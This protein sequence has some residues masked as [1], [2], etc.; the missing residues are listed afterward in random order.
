MTKKSKIDP[1][2]RKNGDNFFK[3]SSIIIIK[4]IE[5]IDFYPVFWLNFMNLVVGTCLDFCKSLCL[6]ECSFLH[7]K[8]CLHGLQ[9]KNDFFLMLKK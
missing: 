2:K 5:L 1:K 9:E 3:M 4:N 6:Y 7:I 8:L